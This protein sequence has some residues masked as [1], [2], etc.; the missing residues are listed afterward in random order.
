MAATTSHDC[1][2]LRTPSLDY[3]PSTSYPPTGR[4]TDVLSSFPRPRLSRETTCGCSQYQMRGSPQSSSR[5]LPRRCTATFRQTVTSSRTRRTSPAGLRC[6]SRPF[7]GRTGSGRSRPMAATSRDGEQMVERST[8]CRTI[9]N[10]WPCRSVKVLRLVFP[11]R[12]FKH[13]SL[14]AQ[15]PI[16]RISF[17]VAT[18]K[19]F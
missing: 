7:R 2:P 18:G 4:Q 17:L 5:R 3:R 13:A 9:G 11:S 16:A 8:T 19:N 12:C 15:M 10:S 1:Q 6:T 14:A